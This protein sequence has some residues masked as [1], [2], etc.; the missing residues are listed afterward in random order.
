MKTCPKCGKAFE[1]K[2]GNITQC[3]CYRVSLTRE[4]SVFIKE[5]YNDCLCAECLIK[6][7]EIFQ[8]KKIIT[9]FRNIQ[10]EY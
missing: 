10:K 8:Q 1:C 6:L 9:Y 2:P 5:I 7:K 3:Q 4:E